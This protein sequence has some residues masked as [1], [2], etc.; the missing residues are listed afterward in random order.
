MLLGNNVGM[1]NKQMN[2]KDKAR[3]VVD[4]FHKRGNRGLTQLEHDICQLLDEKDAQ[5]VQWP[6]EEGFKE[7]HEAYEELFRYAPGKTDIYEF[8]K[9]HTAKQPQ[10][11]PRRSK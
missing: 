9:S 11:C 7:W 1:N 8:F 3:Q 6:S 4:M 5:S 10:A 2:N